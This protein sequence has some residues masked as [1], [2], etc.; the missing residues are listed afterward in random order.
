MRCVARRYACKLHLHPVQVDRVNRGLTRAQIRPRERLVQTV[1]GRRGFWFCI[2]CTVIGTDLDDDPTH[3]FRANKDAILPL[4]QPVRA[5]DGTMM[6]EIPVPKG[7]VVL[8]NIPATNRNKAVWG[9]DALE[10]R[11]E[12]W[13]EPVPQSVEEARVPGIYAN[14]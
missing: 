12:R 4:S 1:S 10:W 3:D 11:P 2:G 14:L 5:V 9:E 13:L 8:S 7:T 6:T